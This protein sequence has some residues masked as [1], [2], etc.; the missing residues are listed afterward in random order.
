MCDRAAAVDPLLVETQRHC[1]ERADAKRMRIVHQPGSL[2][3]QYCSAIVQMG[4]HELAHV[5]PAR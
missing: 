3:L 5:R 1:V 2:R 4:D